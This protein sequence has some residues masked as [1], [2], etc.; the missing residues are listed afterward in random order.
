MIEVKVDGMQDLRA[1]L[2]GIV[3]KLRRR[4]LRQALAAGAR[5]VQREARLR[6]P[7]LKLSTIGGASAVRRGVRA[8]GTVKR[9]ISVRTSKISA[10]LGDVGVFVNVRPAKRAQRGARNPADPYYWRWLEFG[11]NPAG[12][13]TGGRLTPAGKRKRRQLVRSG[14]AKHKPGAGFMQAGARM[15]RQ[16]LDTFVREIGPRIARLNAGKAAQP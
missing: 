5:L 9:A 14:A 6:A 13:T 4:A 11:W 8:P 10:R 3:P 2:L 15:L 12:A 7:V 1:A 16:A